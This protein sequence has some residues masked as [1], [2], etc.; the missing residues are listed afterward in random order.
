MLKVLENAS[1]SIQKKPAKELKIA[2]ERLRENATLEVIAT[3]CV[4]LF[5]FLQY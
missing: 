4:I 2:E 3:G 1:K 5:F